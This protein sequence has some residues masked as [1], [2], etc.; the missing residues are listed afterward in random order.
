MREKRKRG[1]C[2]YLHFSVSFP[3][4][5]KAGQP[6]FLLP[7]SLYLLFVHRGENYPSPPEKVKRKMQEKVRKVGKDTERAIGWEHTYDYP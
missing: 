3:Y 5:R 7:F 6:P 2:A 4:G 1:V